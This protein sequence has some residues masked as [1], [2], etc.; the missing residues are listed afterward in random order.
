MNHEWVAIDSIERCFIERL[1]KMTEA[2][3]ME[4]TQRLLSTPT[5]YDQKSLYAQEKNPM[6]KY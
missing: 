4:E 6:E 3:F 5:R 2:I 1:R